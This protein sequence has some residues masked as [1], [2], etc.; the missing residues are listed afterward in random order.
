MYLLLD[1]VAEDLESYCLD[2]AVG[3]VWKDP[4]GAKLLK[5]T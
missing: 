2:F 4:N 5:N 1:E 3:W